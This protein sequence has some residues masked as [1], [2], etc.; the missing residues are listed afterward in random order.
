MTCQ[1]LCA[2]ENTLTSVACQ[3][4]DS[5]TR[6]LLLRLLFARVL[7]ISGVIEICIRAWFA[8]SQHASL[9]RSLGGG[10][11]DAL[12]KS[13]ASCALR[14]RAGGTMKFAKLLMMMMSFI[15]SCRNKNQPKATYPKGTSHHTRLFRGPS[16]N[17]MKKQDGPSRSWPTPHT[18]PFS[19]PPKT[20]IRS[21]S[22]QIR[23][24]NEEK[25][26]PPKTIPAHTRSHRP[27]P[28]CRVD[29]HQS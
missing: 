21:Y 26:H 2:P 16:T 29:E 1:S 9:R 3:L 28:M 20:P 17:G 27:H 19:P 13:I 4:L 14:H 23:S 6:A 7:C 5:R 24:Q 25:N 18:T 10:Y 8:C 15:Y 11:L 22:A 12:G